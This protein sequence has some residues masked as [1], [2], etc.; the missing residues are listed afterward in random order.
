MLR[1]ILASCFFF[2]VSAFLFAEEGFDFDRL[3]N[4]LVDAASFSE[5]DM[6]RIVETSPIPDASK[7]P[8]QPLSMVF[9]LIPILKDYET[10]SRFR[11][12]WSFTSL[13]NFPDFPPF[14]QEKQKIVSG[15]TEKEVYTVLRKKGIRKVACVLD[16]DKGRGRVVFDGIRNDNGK[17]KVFFT[18]NV[19][20]ELKKVG[21]DW[22]VVAFILSNG[23]TRTV[24]QKDGSWK[25]EGKTDDLF[26]PDSASAR[27]NNAQPP[28]QL[29]V[30]GNQVVLDEN[31]DKT[32]RLAG[33]NIPSLEWSNG[34]EHVFESLDEAYWSWNCNVI[35]LPLS[36][37]RWYGCEE[38]QKSADDYRNIVDNVVRKASDYGMYVI[39]DCHWSNGG[40]GDI[41]RRDGIKNTSKA[42]KINGQKNMPDDEVLR[43]WLDVS[44]LYGNNPAVLF[45]LYNEPHGVSW[46]V[47]RNGGTVKTRLYN[48]ET[49]QHEDGEYEAVGHQTLIEAIRDAGARNVIVVGGLDWGY[50]LRGVAG[51]AGDGK[52]YA[53]VDRNG[54]DD[55]E[56]AGF[57]IIYDTHIYPWK[58]VVQNWENAVGEARKR[59]PIIA[60]ECGWDWSTIKVIRPQTDLEK[61][62]HLK[63]ENWVPLLLDWFDA[64]TSEIGTEFGNQVHWTG[65][66]FHPAASPRLLNDWDYTPTPFWGV[67]VKE[68]L[69]N[70]PLH[71]VGA[72]KE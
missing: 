4:M 7:M 40:Q 37:A 11:E 24:L 49:D 26:S 28:P 35:R 71:G 60:G 20:F 38:W 9:L 36:V 47:W 41:L 1:T 17:D 59:F 16:G 72:A 18:A 64:E 21:G 46:E 3:E 52:D 55:P 12:N 50:D 44:A 32:I 30:V 62:T 29:R 25:L 43:F 63:S 39:L 65:W 66:C 51:E 5:D 69:R 2:S 67:F 13:A 70:Y 19:D 8:N 22:R 42:R 34:G 61:E 15:E 45:N 57:G 10:N 6:K 56:K 54:D 48:P 27:E 23:Q 14:F 33:L 53:L 31:R 68:R 58:G